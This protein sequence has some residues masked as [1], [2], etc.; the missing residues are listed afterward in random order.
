MVPAEPVSLL[1]LVSLSGL[2]AA[3]IYG[4]PDVMITGIATCAQK[5]ER[6]QMFAAIVGTKTDS[7]MLI[8]EAVSRGAAAI[9]VEK[10]IPPYPGVTMVRVPDTRMALGPLAHAFYGNPSRAMTVVG[11]TGTNG[12]T[13]TTSMI[14]GILEAA[15]RK[16]GLIGTLGAFWDG[17]YVD[18]HITTPDS[19]TLA[20]FFSSMEKDNVQAV[21]M[22]ASSHG[23]HQARMSG[24]PF[25]AGVLTNVTQDHLDY[26]GDYPT[27]IATKR[28][29]FFDFVDPTPGATACFNLD[30]PI[31]EELSH[32]Y[33]GDHFTYARREG[34]GADFHAED[35]CFRPDGTSFKL[36]AGKESVTVNARMLGAF[37]LSNMLAAAS[38]C[39]SLG[40]DLQTIANGL[41]EVGPISGRFERI[42][43]GQPF[44]VIVDFAHTPDALE[45][46]LQTAR[47]LTSGDLITVF[48]CGG[49]RDRT[50]RPPMGKA[51]GRR[52]DYAIVT[53]DNPR[54]ED[55]ER[56]ARGA[57]EGLLQSGLKPANYQVVLDRA[58][59][60]ERALLLAKS[61]DCVVIA[62]KGHETYQ[63]VCGR[64]LQFDDRVI[65]R[66]VLRSMAE[67]WEQKPAETEVK[68]NRPTWA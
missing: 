32:S 61:G 25:H 23:I 42:D 29:F 13:T 35:V 68:S 62:G 3:D 27:Y 51:V 11:V 41:E 17:K 59:A 15:G 56:I 45:K 33:L 44:Q 60:I 49:D 19:M 66:E 12:K 57:L 47:S 67:A 7:H 50:K 10:D 31:G 6:N 39:R 16:T 14:A 43:E 40:I 58:L 46:V 36:V 38:A 65:A 20:R 34:L 53:S 21:V 37:N 9:L 54:F 26:H 63:E 30:D 5:V 24:L 22:E 52:T 18:A 1:H 28:Q 2:L 48:G 55:P 4:N 8:S 64:K